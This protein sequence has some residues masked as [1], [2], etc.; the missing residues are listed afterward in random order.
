MD[1][2]K[3]LKIAG[4]GAVSVAVI[5]FAV[6]GLSQT[7]GNPIYG[8]F[9]NS[10]NEL[11]PSKIEKDDDSEEV[12]EKSK[13][14]ADSEEAKRDAE[15][16]RFAMNKIN[17]W[18]VEDI[19][20]KPQNADY[21]YKKSDPDRKVENT[22]GVNNESYYKKQIESFSSVY[23]N[24]KYR[25][26]TDETY[27]KAR[28]SFSDA[29]N[30]IQEHQK[31]TEEF[32][33]AS[34]KSEDFQKIMIEHF[35]SDGQYLKNV[36]SAMQIS[37]S[38]LELDADTFR[39]KM[40]SNESKGVYAF[41]AIMKEKSSGQQYAYVSGYYNSKLDYFDVTSSIYLLDG[42]VGFDKW[43]YDAKGIQ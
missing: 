13:L 2:D 39:L 6:F 18:S 43:T 19:L 10:A 29:M 1:K 25:N 32:G 21:Q 41:E 35:N 20:K 40:T 33:G 26:A 27:E 37:K 16:S 17:S 22:R 23:Q 12:D 30:L 36:I 24:R 8:F 38:N 11:K 15:N 9:N 28:N 4:I 34:G 14:S 42:A 31:Q 3:A 7:K 5:S